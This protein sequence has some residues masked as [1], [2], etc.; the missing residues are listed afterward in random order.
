MVLWGEWGL[1]F[2][3]IQVCIIA[4][5]FFCPHQ[6]FC[7]LTD[8]QTKFSYLNKESLDYLEVSAIGNTK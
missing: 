1:S 6:I 3:N 5:V 8:T 7:K 2:G 4:C